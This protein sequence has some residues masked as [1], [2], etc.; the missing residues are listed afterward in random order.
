[1]RLHYQKHGRGAPVVILH[2]LFGSLDNWSFISKEL[3]SQFEVIAC[4]LRNHGHSPH[5]GGMSFAAMAEDVARVI[6]LEGLDSANLLGHSLGGK[7]AM[8]FAL[9]FPDRTAKLVVVDIATRAYAPAH[10]GILEALLA[11]PLHA[12]TDRLA[13]EQALASS[14]P[15]LAVRR[16]LLKN[17][18][19]DERGGFRWKLDLQT[20]AREYDHL[21]KALAGGRVF[22]GP[23]LFIRGAESDYI[24]STDLEAARPLFPCLELKTINGAGHWVHA[25]KPT[26]FLKVVVDFL[27]GESL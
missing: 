4:D 3:A 26:E 22:K 18:A 15:D 9:L 16:F 2:G 17:L 23:T 21:N 14:V 13:V 11:L 5:S 24:A 7:V 1:M 6:S 10:R 19:R 25:D 8:E 12:F 27:R 20:I